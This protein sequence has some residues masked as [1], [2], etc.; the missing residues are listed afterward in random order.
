M[1][2]FR[3][4]ISLASEIQGKMASLTGAMEGHGIFRMDR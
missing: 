4:M 3:A 1:H 2:H